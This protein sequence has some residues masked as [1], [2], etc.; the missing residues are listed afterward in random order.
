M[1]WSRVALRHEQPSIV[2]AALHVPGAMRE[3]TFSRIVVVEP[4]TAG[5][6]SVDP[7]C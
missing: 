1:A 2:V 3:T 4:S 5:L 7:A 6:W